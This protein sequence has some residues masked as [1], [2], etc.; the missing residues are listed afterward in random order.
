MSVTP[1]EHFLQLL[2]VNGTD[3][4]RRLIVLHSVRSGYHYR[5]VRVQRTDW[6]SIP[7]GE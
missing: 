6:K 4:G 3:R 1:R 2:V 5:V 7:H